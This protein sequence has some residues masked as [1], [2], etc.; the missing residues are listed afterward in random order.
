MLHILYGPRME[1]ATLVGIFV[2]FTFTE[3]ICLFFIIFPSS[4]RHSERSGQGSL[5]ESGS[6]PCSS[7]SASLIGRRRCKRR[8]DWLVDLVRSHRDATDCLMELLIIAH[9]ALQLVI[10][11]GLKLASSSKGINLNLCSLTNIYI[12]IYLLEN[13]NHA[14]EAIQSKKKEKGR[15]FLYLNYCYMIISVSNEMRQ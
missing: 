10:K 8:P 9:G 7:Q 11:A 12:Y 14:S 15:D 2:G 3:I 6:A 13:M 1:L 5:Y 4:R